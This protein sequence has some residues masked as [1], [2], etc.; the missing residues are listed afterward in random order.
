MHNVCRFMRL[1]IKL[2][3]GFFL[4]VVLAVGVNGFYGVRG[5]LERYERD[6]ADRHVVM[7]LVLRAAFS[8]VMDTDGEARA[9]SVL[10]YTDK[11]FRLVNI[12]WVYLEE[13]A[14]PERAPQSP[15][16]RLR[17][18]HEGHEVHDKAPGV[19]R[20]YVPMHIEGRPLTAL[21]LAETLEGERSVV[22]Q[23]ILRE[24]RVVGTMALGIG[25]VASVLGIL[26][27]ARPIR[28]LVA[29]ARRVGAGDFSPRAVALGTDEI[30]ELA[31]EM[32]AM[33]VQ[34]SEAQA[35]KLRALEQL[36][37]AERLSTVGALASGLAHELGTPLNVITLRATAIA[38]GRA[39]GER[40]LDAASSIVQQARRMTDLVRQLL[41]FARQRRPWS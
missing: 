37:H 18:L 22:R 29:H 20:S 40:T 30:A 27:V 21:E 36:R 9:V 2:I 31:R 34:L 10:D 7:G 11:R 12:R 6:I 28:G 4:G 32:I 16:H 33:C 13:G 38:R 39:V 3:A 8:E 23:T 26:L 5:E 41:D 14:P 24:L 1:T 35:A 15:I 19:M 17:P 25:L